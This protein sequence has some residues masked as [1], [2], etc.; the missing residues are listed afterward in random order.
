MQHCLYQ[1]MFRNVHESKKQPVKSGLVWSRKLSILPSMHGEIVS[2][3]AFAQWA[4]IL[5]NFT[6]VS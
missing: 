4:D 3:P 1:M 6:A 5:G 2:M